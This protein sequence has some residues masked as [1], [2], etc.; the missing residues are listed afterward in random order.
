MIRLFLN[1]SS[2]FAAGLRLDLPP[3]QGRYL[4][5]VMRL[6]AGD[7]VRLFNGRDGEWQARIAEATRKAV[8]LELQT[9]TRPQTGMR[10]LVLAIALIKRTR[11][12]TVIEKATELGV[13]AI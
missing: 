11:L 5:S 6:G 1:S 13:S 7:E 2:D 10:D 3:D 4:T 12:E 9:Q 8:R